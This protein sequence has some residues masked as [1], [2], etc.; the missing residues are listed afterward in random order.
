VRLTLLI[1][2][3][4]LSGVLSRSAFTQQL[5]S[6]DL[7]PTVEAAA[8]GGS[9]DL[10]S[11]AAGA[12]FLNPANLVG[13]AGGSGIMGT[14]GELFLAG[15]AAG[16][17]GSKS[18][19]GVGVRSWRGSPDPC[20]IDCSAGVQS[21]SAV[22]V[23]YGRS[24]LGFRTGLLL[25]FGQQFAGSEGGRMNLVDFGVSREQGPVHVGASVRG[26]RLVAGKSPAPGPV[27][28]LQVS[29]DQFQAGPLD[30][31][32]AGHM[33]RLLEG[34]FRDW[35]QRFTAFGVG[36]RVAYWPVTGRT[37]RLLLGVSRPMGEGSAALSVGG[38]FTGD[39]FT[40]EYAYQE[41]RGLGVHR[42]GLRWRT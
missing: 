12:M 34:S 31:L 35:N 29:S 7:R 22:S 14:N 20:G 26:L 30:I 23:G 5:T 9:L 10:G 24:V 8:M 13:I 38:S 18:G 28:D 19:V 39:T 33:T 27:A 32:L 36:A 37:F 4:A 21:E 25:T 2:L 6:L 41:P 11:S 1:V 17:S 3:T 40:L 42:F 16:L 15:A